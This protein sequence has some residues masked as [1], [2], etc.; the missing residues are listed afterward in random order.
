VKGGK[1]NLVGRGGGAGSLRVLVAAGMC[2]VTLL[3]AALAAPPDPTATPT[4]ADTELANYA[5]ASELGSGIYSVNGQAITVYQLPFYYPLRH[6]APRGGRPGVKLL[7]PLTF[8]FFNFQPIDLA[9]GSIPTSVGALSLEPGIELEWWLTDAWHVYPYVKAGASFASSSAVNALIYGAGVR[10]DYRFGALG[11]RGLY[12]AVVAYGGVHYRSEL[13]NDSFTRLRNG[14][15]L[16]HYLPWQV[17]G[18]TL[19][20]GPYAFVDY[21]FNAPTGP[22]SGISANTWQLEAGVMLDVLPGWT[23][24]SWRVPRLGLGYR[25]AGILSGWRLVIGD[26]F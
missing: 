10:S 25:A 19:E 4:A 23:I 13:P 15:E 12:S 8:G 9:H 11:S 14:L 6:A 3:P 20:L 17:R 21:Y 2:A 1:I 24:G 7:F 16:R 26:P 5:F 22:A 18:R